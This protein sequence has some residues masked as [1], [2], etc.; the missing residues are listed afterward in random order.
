MKIKIPCTSANLGVLFDKGG[1]ALDAFFN[2][3]TIEK[4]SATK[5]SIEGLGA[6]TLPRDK[7]NLVCT[8]ISRYY[9]SIGRTEPFYNIHMKNS[10]PLSRGLGSSAACIAG[11]LFAANILEGNPLTTEELIHMAAEME[12]HGDNVCPAI[13]GGITLYEKDLIRSFKNTDD[14]SFIVYIP[15]SELSTKKSRAVLP[16]TYPVEI[17]EKAA[18]LESEM[19]KAF[20]QKDY[21]KA[22]SLM[23]QDVIHQ[24][25][26]KILVPFWDDVIKAAENAGV[27]GTALSGAGPA[28]ISFCSTS[29]KQTIL[30]KISNAIDI[31]HG[32]NI[33]GCEICEKG[34]SSDYG[35]SHE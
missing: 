28:M 25:Y 5:I 35:G 31:N 2:E 26:R 11:G 7:S 34:I 3:I 8:A 14:L 27:Y 20:E 12:G 22:G 32:L 4:S 13:L 18:F 17:I 23:K 6:A 1:V 10:I 19:I 29:E 30:K 15:Q 9:Q 33:I 24:P 21:K 16:K